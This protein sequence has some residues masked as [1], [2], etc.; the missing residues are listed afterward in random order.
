MSFWELMPRFGINEEE[1]A[2]QRWISVEQEWVEAARRRP[3]GLRRATLRS[4]LQILVTLSGDHIGIHRSPTQF[5]R[6]AGAPTTRPA[7]TEPRNRTSDLTDSVAPELL[8]N[9]MTDPNPAQVDNPAAAVGL[10]AAYY[11]ANY[12][13]FLRLVRARF[14]SLEPDEMVQELFAKILDD[15]A[16]VAPDDLAQLTEAVVRWTGA[17]YAARSLVNLCLDSIQSTAR[18]VQAPRATGSAG[19]V[20][21]SDIDP[22]ATDRLGNLLSAEPPTLEPRVPDQVAEHLDALKA[23]RAVDSM[24]QALVERGARRQR[25][26]RIT[27]RQFDILLALYSSDRPTTSDGTELTD[28]ELHQITL[29]ADKRARARWRTQGGYSDPESGNQ[30]AAA[31]GLGISTQAISQSRKAVR[32][33]LI[34]TKYVAGVLAPA[35]TLLDPL[36]IHVHLDHYDRMPERAGGDQHHKEL[37]AAAAAVRTSPETGTRVH[38]SALTNPGRRPLRE[39]VDRLHAAESYLAD[40]SGSTHPNCVAICAVHT[41][42]RN[43]A[44]EV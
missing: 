25:V 36:A 18:R 43:R 1:G 3:Q 34:V 17:G 2:R 20:D 28:A 40:L 16:A 32:A 31:A 39:L 6:R 5:R 23:R 44:T 10:V 30:A 27:Q 26:T 13:R 29:E 24:L 15:L 7:A 4:E 38:P 21:E 8:E 14:S 12:S 41:G 42:L 19:A 11:K 33:A 37:T 35:G 9:L 22:V